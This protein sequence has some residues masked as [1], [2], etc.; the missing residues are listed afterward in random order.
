[1]MVRREIAEPRRETGT[2]RRE[3]PMRTHAVCEEGPRNEAAGRR[4]RIAYCS[5]NVHECGL[6]LPNSYG[7][8]LPGT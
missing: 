2:R 1:M 7:W 4:Q 3:D 6:G 5:R 8:L